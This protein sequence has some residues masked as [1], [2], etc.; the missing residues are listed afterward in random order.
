MKYAIIFHG[1]AGNADE[2]WFPWLKKELRKYN[3]E[4]IVPQFPTP[5]NQTPENWLKVF[6]EY[7]NKKYLNE[8]AI[9]IGHSLGGG[10]LLWVL[11]KIGTKINSDV[12]HKSNNKVKAVFFVAASIGVKP[13]KYYETDKPFVEKEFDWQKI[14][15]AAKKFFVFHSMDDPF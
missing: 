3:Y 4:V 7:E 8:D 14:R 2:N 6:E 5:K 12:N 1:T 15:G 11:E 13:I 9:L 10:F